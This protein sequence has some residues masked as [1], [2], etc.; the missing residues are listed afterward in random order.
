MTEEERIKA[1]AMFG[2]LG[3][4]V[5]SKKMTKQAKS[6]RGKKAINTRWENYRKQ[7]E[8]DQAALK[9]LTAE[10]AVVE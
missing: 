4:L 1:A 10:A 8:I 6:D 7:K 2:R 3:G 5:S 9:T